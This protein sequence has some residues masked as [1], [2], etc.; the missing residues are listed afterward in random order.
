MASSNHGSTLKKWMK[1]QRSSTHI[2]VMNNGFVKSWFYIKKM[3][4][5]TK[6]FNSHMC[7]EQWLHQ[8]WFYIKK[9]DETT[10]KF[11]S[12]MCHEPWL[13]Q[14]WFYIL[15]MD[16]TTKKFNSHM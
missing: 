9:M 7:H 6:K 1:P 15:K 13:R 10:K 4:E 5:T 16:E 2:C 11:N 12:H 8:T 14:T 3:D